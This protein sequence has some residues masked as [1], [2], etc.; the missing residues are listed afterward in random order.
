VS[1]TEAADAPTAS[2]LDPLGRLTLLCDP[3]SLE[4]ARPPVASRPVGVLAATG[5]V[6][7]RPVVCYAQ[8]SA[9]AGGSVGTAEADTVVHALRLARH[10]RTPLIAFL[11]SAGARLQEG[12]AALGGFGRIFYE[13]VSLS[14][15]APQISVVTGTSAG[16]GCYSPA[17]TDFIVMTRPS[18]MYLTGPRV[19]RAAVGE[20]V[21]SDALG[22]PDVHQRNGVCDFVVDD[23]QE[24]VAV[25]RE[26]LDYLPPER[27][28]TE[29]SSARS[30]ADPGRHVPAAARKVYD[31]RDV[32]RD[33]VDDSHM[34]EVS[35]RWARN[36]VVGFARL[37]GQPVGIVANQPR[38]LGGVLD[39]GASEKGARFVGTCQT[40][41]LPL[42]VLVD[43]PGFMPGTNQESRGV[44]RHGAALVRAFAS[45]T[46]PR[47][48]VVLRKA[49]GG[50]YITMNAK[51][52]GAD[53]A[54]AWTDAQI[55]IMGP[56]AAIQIIHRRELAAAPGSTALADEL[57]ADYAARHI[58]AD[59]ALELG[60]VDAVIHPGE[61][62]ARLT[63]A[64][65][66]MLADGRA[67]RPR[68]AATA[69]DTPVL[70]RDASP[71]T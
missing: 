59:R 5:C 55:G 38:H 41:G 22:G 42:I 3:G 2:R 46:V 52:L 36:I 67:S 66:G 50:A 13:N 15:R 35:P 60:L 19:V 8:D 69:V 44:I 58:A 48:T 21:S 29:P 6:R 10:T 40:F 34:L 53:L 24:A 49:F 25:V 31:V 39:V 45:A 1:R 23:D 43:T 47:L 63:G 30:D 7:G 4:W 11:E 54:L 9:L 27:M 65:H 37:G 16:G 17:L 71:A 61:T 14:G 64:L 18:A 68:R 33:I 12:A 26:L 28:V 51:D 57:A 56:R 20:E 62:R 32:V 70:Q